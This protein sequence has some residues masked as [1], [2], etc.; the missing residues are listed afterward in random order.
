MLSE[1]P[2]PTIVTEAIAEAS[3]GITSRRATDVSRSWSGV[4]D[5]LVRA[6]ANGA[7]GVASDFEPCM[8][9]AHW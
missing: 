8:R 9:K 6:L 3:A 5:S 7:L 4:G 2:M 1:R